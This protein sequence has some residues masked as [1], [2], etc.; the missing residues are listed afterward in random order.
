MIMVED[1]DDLRLF[2]RNGRKVIFHGDGKIPY[3]FF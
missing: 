3:T 2:V 1:Q